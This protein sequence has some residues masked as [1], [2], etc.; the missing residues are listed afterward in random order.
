[1]SVE[2]FAEPHP[3]WSANLTGRL[4]T[5]LRV[6]DLDY[7]YRQL[8]AT[9]IAATNHNLKTTPIRDLSHWL[10]NKTEGGRFQHH[11]KRSVSGLCRRQVVRQRMAHPA[12]GRLRRADASKQLG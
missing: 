10:Y 5:H 9:H 12:G 11:G 6:F 4:R 1:M 8:D 2:F 3:G 7:R